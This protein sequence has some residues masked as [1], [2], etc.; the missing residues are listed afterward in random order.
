MRIRSR[1]FATSASFYT[2]SAAV[3]LLTSCSSATD[4]TPPPR[5]L[6][7]PVG[8]MTDTLSDHGNVHG[9]AIAADGTMLVTRLES[10][11]LLKSHISD[12]STSSVI[13]VGPTPVDVAFSADSRTAFIPLIGSP[14]VAIVDV[15][16]GT[17]TGQLTVAQSPLRALVTPD[18]N[19]LYITT[20]GPL[21][22]TTSTV[23]DFDAHTHA[24]LDTI[25]VTPYANGITYD[26][27]RSELFVA[28]AGF[29]NEIYPP[30][31]AIVRRIPVN[32]PMQDIAISKDG[33][34]L[35]VA[36]TGDAGVEVFD[37]VS[38]ELKQSIA[39]TSGAF[40]LKMTPDGK[41]FYVT[42][43]GASMCA[44]IDAA[45]RTVVK[46]FITGTD[47]KRIA[48]NADGSRAAITDG[49]TGVVIIQ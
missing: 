34:E 4:S 24:L 39:G 44:I 43:N 23:Y 8:N 12:I 38:G 16:S 11:D 5:G 36:T 21:D 41:Q 7:H 15:Q 10:F 31:D 6:T 42:R 27:V 9:I 33:S 48:F 28:S 30:T 37:L 3:A 22:D 1:L 25:V 29:V 20:D 32:L 40:G 35:W 19:N 2:L 49:L 46:S 47:P 17:K 26:P 14:H 45:S 18:G 13:Y